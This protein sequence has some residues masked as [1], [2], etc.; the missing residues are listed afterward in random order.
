MGSR[1]CQDRCKFVKIHIH[2]S[3]AYKGNCFCKMCSSFFEKKDLVVKNGLRCP[4][5][6]NKVRMSKINGR[7]KDVK[8]ISDTPIY[9]LET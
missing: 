7:R 3:K 9:K 1:G 6:N 5:C 8:R 2:P 4:C